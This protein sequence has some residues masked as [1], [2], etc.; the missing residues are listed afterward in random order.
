MR[1]EQFFFLLAQ[2]KI[3]IWCCN[4]AST[5]PDMVSGI[6]WGSFVDK[7][8]QKEWN[9]KNCHKV[10]GGHSKRNCPVAG[11]F[12]AYIKSL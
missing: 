3:L 2:N 10:I 6:T 5:Y 8:G 12:A 4:K 9:D 1:I 11:N 7:V